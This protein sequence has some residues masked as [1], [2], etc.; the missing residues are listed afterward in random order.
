VAAVVAVLIPLVN[1]AAQA[2][3]FLTPLAGVGALAVQ[4]DQQWLELPVLFTA[5]EVRG[6]LLVHQQQQLLEAQAGKA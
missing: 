1:L 2:L 3:T 6:V 4:Q 5:L